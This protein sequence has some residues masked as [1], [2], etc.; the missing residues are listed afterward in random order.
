MNSGISE[1]LRAAVVKKQKTLIVEGGEKFD[2]AGDVCFSDC[3]ERKAP[4]LHV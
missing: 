4:A 3:L 1:A 2:V